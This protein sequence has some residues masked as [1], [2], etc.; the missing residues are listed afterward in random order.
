MSKEING[1]MNYQLAAE[2]LF[3]SSSLHYDFYNKKENQQT[4]RFSLKD[5]IRYEP[6]KISVL[7]RSKKILQSFVMFCP[8]GAYIN[9]EQRAF[10]QKIY[11]FVPL[12]LYKTRG[13]K[14]LE[15]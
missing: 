14:C 8:Q 7:S 3:F 10:R 15:L 6:D 1:L 12:N 9:R 2:F 5:L 13:L 4:K 11:E